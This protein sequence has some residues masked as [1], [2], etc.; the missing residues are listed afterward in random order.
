ATLT[1]TAVTGIGN[2]TQLVTS[3]LTSGSASTSGDGAAAVNI[4]NSSPSATTVSSLATVG[5]NAPITFA[6]SGGG[7]LTVTS[8]TTTDGAINLSS[9][10]ANLTATS[11]SAGG[12]SNN[13]VALTTTT[14]G[15]I[16]L[17][18]INAPIQGL[19]VTGAGTVGLP[20]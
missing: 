5:A 17:S 1:A 4:A 7:A 12:S 3:G 8:A 6:Q 10:S 13:T 15:N 11:L 19:T 14:S 18:A 16:L 20:G 9:D 2:T